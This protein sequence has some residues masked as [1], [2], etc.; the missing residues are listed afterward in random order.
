MGPVERPDARDGAGRRE[1]HHAW[2]R[3]PGRRCAPRAFVLRSVEPDLRKVTGERGVDP[4]D[5]LDQGRMGRQQAEQFVHAPDGLAEEHVARLFGVGVFNARPLGQ[6]TDLFQGTGN[7]VGI[8]RELHRRRVGQE[9]AL[10]RH[11]RL[12]HVG[13]KNAHVAD[14]VQRQAD[15]GER[16]EPL[17]VVISRPTRTYPPPIVL[18]KM[19]QPVRPI[20]RMPKSTP[21]SRMLSRMSPFKMWLNS[22]AITPCS[23]SR[24]RRESVPLVTATTASPVV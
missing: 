22:W 17:A 6:G 15:Q 8:P 2:P 19:I 21:M 23:S 9:L 3:P 13:E 18:R 11:G 10:A 14:H 7:A 20:T 16:I 24:D 4:P 5:S 12:D 1:R